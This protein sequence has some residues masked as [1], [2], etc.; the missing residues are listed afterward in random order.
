[1][2][3]FETRDGRKISIEAEPEND[4]IISLLINTIPRLSYD[5]ILEK[6][7]EKRLSKVNIKSVKVS[8]GDDVKTLIFNLAMF[9]TLSKPMGF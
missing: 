5:E 8:S 7:I 1:M 6:K 9:N 2:H 4:E 3:K